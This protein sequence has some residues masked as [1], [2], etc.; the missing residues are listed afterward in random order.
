LGTPD[1]GRSE[2][3]HKLKTETAMFLFTDGLVDRPGALRRDS[4]RALLSACHDIGGASAWASE[5]A[6]RAT[7]L[8]GQPADDATVVSVR[9]AVEATPAQEVAARL[10]GR[11]VLRAYVDPRDLRTPG[12]LDV[13]DRLGEMVSGVAL[14]VEVIDVTSKSAMIEEAGVLAAPTILRARPE[15]KVRVIGWFDSPVPLARALQLPVTAPS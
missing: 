13:L 1:A 12:L 2:A 10:A 11:V 14:G 8:F 9:L 6:R 4:L 15:P 7:G 3:L 5:F